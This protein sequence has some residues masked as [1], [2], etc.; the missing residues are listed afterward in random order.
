MPCRPPSPLRLSFLST[1]SC[2][3]HSAPPSS[4]ATPGREPQP[5]AL[6]TPLR[7]RDAGARAAG[8]SSRRSPSSTPAASRVH[9]H[10]SAPRHP[11]PPPPAPV[12][13]PAG[14]ATMLTPV[15]RLAACR[16]L[17]LA[18]FSA[19]EAAARR[20]APSLVYCMRTYEKISEAHQVRAEKKRL[21][22]F[23]VKEAKAA[24]EKDR[25]QFHLGIVS[26]II[27]KCQS[28]TEHND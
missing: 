5:P 3:A 28:Q 15:A 7:R 25:A 27:I 6:G 2:A 19:S 21:L 24:C 8:G 13:S 12:A 20:L 11:P 23:L 18:S 4:A 22:G 9:L 26:Q 14:H 17:G 1:D 16:L 10:W